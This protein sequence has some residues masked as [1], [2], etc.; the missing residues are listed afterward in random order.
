MVAVLLAMRLNPYTL[1]APQ[2]RP[3]EHIPW[4][5]CLLWSQLPLATMVVVPPALF[6]PSEEM[7][8]HLEAE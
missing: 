2:R 6:C 3:Q 4:A 5:G 8:R 7:E 1:P